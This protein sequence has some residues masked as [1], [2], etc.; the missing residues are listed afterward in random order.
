MSILKRK[1]KEHSVEQEQLVDVRYLRYCPECEDFK[2]Q[3]TI[4][5]DRDRILRCT[6]CK[7]EERFV[8]SQGMLVP[9]G[10]LPLL[11][12]FAQRRVKEIL[13]GE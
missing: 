1:P 12:G 7:T 4:A 5:S 8:F 3:E 6:A 13:R 10:T 9:E 2:P 11:K